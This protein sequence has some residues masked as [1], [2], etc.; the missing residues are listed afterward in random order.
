MKLEPLYSINVTC[1][2]CGTEYATS[3]VRPS[4]KKPI[5]T[6]T[7]FCAYYKAENPDFY[8]VRVCP[9]C[10]FASTEHSVNKLTDK[11]REDFRSQIGSRW[12]GRD[13]SGKRSLEDAIEVYK[14]ALLCAQV[15][16]ERD[17]LIASLLHHI[18]WLYRYQNNTA[19]EQRFLA[20]SL[21]S[22]IRVFE[23]EGVGANDARLLYLIGEINRRLGRFNEAVQWFSRVVRDE[24]IMD[25]AMIRASREQWQLIRQQMEEQGKEAGLS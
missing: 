1:V 20:Y 13:F 5:R 19:Q 16:G 7:D 25:A 6:D 24:K 17:R 12:V 2:Q 15:I 21:D 10:G 22:Y 23:Y 3:R 4:F 18:A 9:K 14:L 8:V 11:Q